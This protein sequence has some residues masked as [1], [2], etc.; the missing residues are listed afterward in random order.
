MHRGTPK[1]GLIADNCPSRHRSFQE[2][3]CLLKR[4]TLGELQSDA[5][6]FGH[7][8]EGFCIEP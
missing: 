8:W 4:R 7:S 6:I 2:Y 3:H 5:S 1:A